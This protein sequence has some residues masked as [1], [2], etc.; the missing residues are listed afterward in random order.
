MKI[1]HLMP[2]SFFPNICGNAY[3]VKGFIDSMDDESV[4][5]VDNKPD[6]PMVYETHGAKVYNGL[7]PVSYQSSFIKNIE[8]VEKPDVIFVHDGQY[9]KF[10][11]YLAKTELP[12]ILVHHFVRA[13]S[14]VK[15]DLADYHAI[16][17]FQERH[18]EHYVLHGLPEDRIFY[19]P[20]PVPDVF[21]LTGVH[22]MKNEVVYAGRLVSSKGVH[23]IFPH[24]KQLG[25]TMTIYGPDN[26]SGYID[27]LKR[28]IEDQDLHDVVDLWV[29]NHDQ[30]VLNAAFNASEYFFIG[31]TSECYS[32]VT[33][34]A[35]ACGCK[36]IVRFNEGAFYWTK[37]LAYIFNDSNDLEEAIQKAML[38]NIDPEEIAK[39]IQSEHRSSDLTKH[40]QP[41]FEYVK[42]GGC[43]KPLSSYM[44]IMKYQM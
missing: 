30:S 6:L 1:M 36:A 42:N 24:L 33:Q 2:D 34:E 3:V 37:D 27:T 20:H 9:P 5:V 8:M 43:V 41:V 40:L 26:D 13:I 11:P 19:V 14:D 7:G 28:M 15:M 4:V 21:K 25:L 31:S 44:R 29:G 23:L 22:R 32:L 39:R 16:L 38:D 18:K 17:V 35:M 12:K 10:E